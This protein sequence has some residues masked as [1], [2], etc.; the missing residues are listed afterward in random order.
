M[1]QIQLVEPVLRND[2]QFRD[3]STKYS[4]HGMH[5]YVAAMVPALA[6]K[7]IQETK[8]TS[9]LDPFCGGGAVCV[10]GILAEI[11][12][13]GLDINHL[14]LVLTNAKTT[15]LDICSIME[16][17][18]SLME[19]ARTQ[20]YLHDDYE[21]KK[22]MIHYWFKEDVIERLGR[23]AYAVNT[24]QDMKLR[25]FFQCVLSGT[26]RDCSLTY[27]NE[28]R[29]HKIRPADY[30][31]FNPDV[32]SIFEK[33]TVSAANAVSL[34][35]VGASADIRHGDILNMPFENGQFTTIITSPPYG[36]ERNGVPYTQFAKNM[37][38]WLGTKKASVDKHKRQTLGWIDKST[39]KH[40]PQTPTLRSLD[41]SMT[42]S[43][44]RRDLAAF[45]HDYDL[46]LGEM[47]RVASDTIVIVI[48][49][50]VLNNLV[51]DNSKITTEMFELHG[52]RLVKHYQ[53]DLPSKRIPKF[54]RSPTVNGGCIDREDILFYSH[55]K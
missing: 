18:Y 51:I 50:R 49:N 5:P 53:R 12:T 27:R 52:L 7:M 22:F 10:E 29:L 42:N 19:T 33:R 15:H 21:Y 36:D 40:L 6:K 34:L 9:L 45:Y 17:Y 43:R 32:M 37:L 47:A 16:Q 26:V 28:I 13:A 30:N 25:M 48:G 31:K 8:P 4:T 55:I 41:Q 23:L 44:S 39:D 2:F 46:A 24:I 20:T 3:M 11:P 14:S 1:A 38:Y 35:P 54:G